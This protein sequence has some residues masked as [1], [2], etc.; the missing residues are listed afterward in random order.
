MLY[1]RDAER[2]VLLRLLGGAREGASGAIVVRGEP[3]VGKSALLADT[4][5]ATGELRVLRATGI[6][7][8]SELAFA[9]LHQLLRG[10]LS[11]IDRI[12]G[13]QADALA[14][15]LG[16]APTAAA[17]PLPGVDRGAQRPCRRG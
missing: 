10:E 9:A 15:A 14:G 7:S 5:G 2:A 16:L 3:G 12:P 4:L 17:G 8:E 1:G 11:R 6:Q 13:R